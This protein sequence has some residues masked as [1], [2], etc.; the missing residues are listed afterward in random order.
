MIDVGSKIKLLRQKTGLTISQL[1]SLSGLSVS[2]ISQCERNI[3]SPSLSTIETLSSIFDVRPSYFLEKDFLENTIFRSPDDNISFAMLMSRASGYPFDFYRIILK[4]GDKREI[5]EN[6]SAGFCN[7][8]YVFKGS[9][10][11][12]GDAV[13]EKEAILISS[14]SGVIKIEALKDSFIV[15]VKTTKS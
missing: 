6:A 3:I 7:F 9:C 4:K 14:E 10:M 8:F 11:I 5:S 13:K 2:M 12:N 15:R 1:S